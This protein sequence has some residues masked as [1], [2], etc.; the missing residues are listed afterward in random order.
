MKSVQL[1]RRVLH[2][3]RTNTSLRHEAEREAKQRKQLSEEVS[4]NY[5]C[6]ERLQ[7]CCF[8]KLLSK[9]YI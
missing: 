1:A 7:F 5:I 9:K 2:L 4:E 3:E 8:L 6:V